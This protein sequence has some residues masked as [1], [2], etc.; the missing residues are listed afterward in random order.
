MQ[1]GGS[2][3]LRASNAAF[4]F[5]CPPNTTLP[6]TLT[7]RKSPTMTVNAAV[8]NPLISSKPS[9]TPITVQLHP[10][11]LLTVSDYITRHTLRQQNGPMMGAIFGQ[12]HG[13]NF[14]LEHAF[15]CKTTDGDSESPLDGEWFTNRLD[16][17]REVHKAPALDL[18]AMFMPGTVDG[19]QPAHLP[20]LAQAQSLGN[21]NI[22]LLIFQLD[23]VEKMEGGKLPI[24]LYEPYQ[25]QVGDKTETRFRE[26]S[27]EVE[28]GDAEM[29][30]VDF[31]ATGGGNA[32]AVPGV[33]GAQAAGGAES[34]SKDKKGKGKGKAKE[35]DAEHEGPATA[36]HLL[37]R[38]DDELISS[39][40]AKANAIK[41]LNQRINLI[42]SYLASLPES[43]LTDASSTTLPGDN[44]NHALLR[45]IN[46]LMSRLP[47][48]APPSATSAESPVSSLDQAASR[49]QQDVHL[50]SLLA[51]LT[52]S[53]SE[54]QTMASRFHVV[55]RERTTKDRGMYNTSQR[56]SSVQEDMLESR[57]T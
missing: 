15:E 38:E 28:T 35:D 43:Y 52:R 27:F 46:S 37:S 9:D 57:E 23:M 51:A 24:G 7:Q 26:L 56:F 48:L 32:T 29:I 45:N 14:T 54:T 20:A 33:Q 36:R 41:M 31:V 6:I 22:M 2:S 42:R 5:T 30:G 3:S 13:R 16:Q 17:Y 19:P 49:E 55:Q 34:S 18:V 10:L 44:T 8:S 53:V 4:V 12:Q 40:T 50:T 11:V 39:L 21:D 47:L 25:E 1:F